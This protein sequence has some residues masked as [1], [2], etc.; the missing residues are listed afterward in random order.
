MVGKDGS[1]Q[2]VICDDVPEMREILGSVLEE[3]PAVV[4]V[5]EATDGREAA[6]LVA[7]L[8]PH[9]VVLDLSMP[10]MDGLEAIPLMTAAAPETG[11]V[12]LSGF[13][14]ERMA[15]AVTDLG[16]D[17]YIE[18]GSPLDEIVRAVRDVAAERRDK[19]TDDLSTRG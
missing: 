2:V 11:I 12:V 16:A 4:I 19:T 7:K 8:R 6:R 5:G 3:D 14:A 13:G 9:V 1:I 17:R 18:K 15:T 10:E